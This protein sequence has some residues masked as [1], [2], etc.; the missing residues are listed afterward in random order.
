MAII[1]LSVTA[2]SQGVGINETGANPNP[3]AILD[4]ESSNKGFLPPRVALTGIND[5]TTII[6]PATGIIVFNTNTNCLQINKGTPS[7]PIWATLQETGATT[8]G[9]TISKRG[10]LTNTGTSVPDS[11]IEIMRN[12][13]KTISFMITKDNGINRLSYGMK[14]SSGS[15]FYQIRT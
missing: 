14:T 6:Q 5:S 2:W 9:V 10:A 13:G 11:E 15:D 4:V 7:Q 3:S 8:T 1:T 12:D